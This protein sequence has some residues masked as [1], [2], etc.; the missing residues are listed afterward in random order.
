MATNHT[1]HSHND[2]K[3]ENKKLISVFGNSF[4]NKELNAIKQVMDSHL[5][6]TGQVATDFEDKFKKR[7][8]FPYAVAC[9]SCTNGFWL[10]LKA[11]KLTPTDEVLIPNCHFFGVKNTLDLTQTN[12]K[13][14]DTQINPPNV[15]V[16][17]IKPHLTPNTKAIIFLEYGG[18]WVDIKAVKKFLKQ[19]NKQVLL[20]LDAANSSI[21]DSDINSSASEYD[22]AIYSF[23]M[24]KL[25]V[26]GDGGM[27]LLKNKNQYKQIKALSYYGL[28]K[29]TT[30]FN[31]A[32]SQQ[33]NW[34]KTS[35]YQPSLK[36]TMNNLTASIGLVQLDKVSGFQQRRR[37]IRD[38]YHKLLAPLVE[39]ELISLSPLFNNKLDGL[40]FFWIRLAST[41]LR[42]KLARFLLK[43]GIYTT[44]KY[45]PLVTKA[46]TPNSHQH[47]KTSLCLPLNQNLT[48]SQQKMIVKNIKL[49]FKKV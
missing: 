23:D 41:Q 42:N 35:D 43:K 36:L 11:L 31:T 12:Y 48:P 24:N 18:Y 30:G 29:P 39:N 27:I 32:K 1:N 40:Y 10:L 33:N 3:K 25:M 34:W 9:N 17:Q 19:Q 22:A 28:T 47:Y 37:E 8:G 26:T 38:Q 44:V 45:Q 2:M 49:F 13:I 15:G 14:I 6:G 7:I 21:P 4:S 46:N 16:E 5:V 20:I